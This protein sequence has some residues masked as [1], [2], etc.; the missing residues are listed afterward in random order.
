VL[1]SVRLCLHEAVCN[2]IIHGNKL[3]NALSVRVNIDVIDDHL[4]IEVTDQGEGFNPKIL[5]DPTK[6]ENVVK[7][8]GRGVYLIR[9]LMNKV[10]FLNDGRTIK[11][12]KKLKK[13]RRG[14][15][16]TSIE[17][18]NDVSVVILE[19]EI[20]MTNVTQ[21]KS[22]ILEILNAGG[23][24]ILIDFEKVAFIDSSGLAVLMDTANRLREAKG[25]LRVCNV[26]RKIFG[27]FEITKIHQMM[28][29]RENREKALKDFG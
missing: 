7:L 1:F 18:I 20:N 16:Q 28:N 17:K 26:N 4:V 11:M 24:K 13:G 22:A 9:R 5:P 25:Q 14:K 29:V 6:P 27:I 8:E 3:N 15:M 10:Q 2:A 23:T 19:G 21:M 12:I